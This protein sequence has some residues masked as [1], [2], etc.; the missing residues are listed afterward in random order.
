MTTASTVEADR[1]VN[2][3]MPHADV[4]ERHETLVRAPADVVFDVAQ[5]VDVQAIPLVRAIFW[6]RGKLLRASPATERRPQ[7]LVAETTALGWGVLAERAG[8]ELVMGAVTRPWEAD[9]K[10]RPLPPYQFAAF[11]EPG[12]VKIVWTLEAEPLGPA[13]TRFRSETRALATDDAARSEFRRYWRWAR[14]GIVLIRWI[15]LPAV[16]REAERRTVV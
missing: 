4:T 3:F 8:R 14:W 2:R 1:L 7:G 6:L 12:L 13:L 5:R 16:R 15:L 11:A 9:V 10:F